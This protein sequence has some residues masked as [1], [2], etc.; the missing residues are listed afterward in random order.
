MEGFIS[1]S[2]PGLEGANA[3]EGSANAQFLGAANHWHARAVALEVQLHE[4]RVKRL[5]WF[6]VGSLV[7]VAGML[8]V[9]V[10]G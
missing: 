7:T 2:V 1:S 5:L 8:L 6:V 3:R 10:L 4:V 9:T